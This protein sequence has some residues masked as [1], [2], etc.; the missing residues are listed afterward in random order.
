MY[1]ARAI[2]IDP[3]FCDAYYDE[4]GRAADDLP[5]ATKAEGATAGLTMRF[6]A[7]EL[8][9]HGH[10]VES[11]AL[12]QRAVTWYR[13]RPAEFLAAAANRFALAQRLYAAEAWSES[14]AIATALL[15]AQK[16]NAVF[17]AL[18]GAAAA[19]RGDHAAAR[20]QVAALAQLP[21]EPGGIVE[22]RRAQL[23]ALLGQNEQAVEL[24][25]DA[26]GRGL[27]M[28]AG[29]HRQIDFESL[30]GFA[31]FDELMKPKGCARP[32]NREPPLRDS[33]A[34]VIA[35][36]SWGRRTS[37]TPGRAPRVPPASTPSTPSRPKPQSL[38][39][40]SETGRAP[41]TPARR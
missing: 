29:L 3:G 4:L 37:G 40:V 8:R 31:P 15:R 5:T 27:S 41:R 34:R 24:L 22:L 25:R 23:T 28:S 14:A 19:R 11:L 7:E 30:R 16:G 10:R 21:S 17:A 2:A 35:T 13:N 9:A 20:V 38:G 36:G 1:S 39:T 26:F 32:A 12:A 33:S 18:S 6:A